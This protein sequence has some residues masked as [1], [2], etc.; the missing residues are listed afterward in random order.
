MT[1]VDPDRHAR[2]EEDRDFLLASLDDLDMELAAGDL[3]EVDYQS[4]R[5]DYTARAAQVIR[6]LA[7]TDRTA[8]PVA[9]RSRPGRTSAW[10]LGV[11]GLAAMAGLLLA[12]FS[13]SRRAGDSITGDIR[14]S[15]R[16]LLFEAQQAFAEGDVEGALAI[17]DEVIEAQPANVEALTYR[18]WLSSRTGDLRTAVVDLEEAIAI[19]PEYADAHVFLAIVALDLDD[20]DRATAEL[21]AFEELDPTPFARQLVADAQV[22]ERIALARVS[23]VMMVG[24]PPPFSESGLTVAELADAAELLASEGELLVAVQLFDDVLSEDP[25]NVEALTYRGWLIAR[26]GDPRLLEGGITMLTTALEL[27][28]SYPPALVFR[29]FALNE[30]GDRTAAA[31]DLAAFDS[32]AERPGD[33]VKLIDDFGLRDAVRGE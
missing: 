4:L 30:S 5:S 28:P 2:L 11:A 32:L 20:P 1:P 29:A 10:I 24:D 18:G 23:E 17:Y 8:T 13:G 12:Q 6:E 9:R 7:D 31:A 33:L 15:S 16:E 3:D 19:D 14:T 27:D 22:R 25:A 26:G 21:A